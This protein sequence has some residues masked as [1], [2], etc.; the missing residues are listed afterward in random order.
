MKMRYADVAGT[1]GTVW[2]AVDASC[3]VT[4]SKAEKVGYDMNAVGTYKLNGKLNN[5][6][7]VLTSYIKLTSLNKTSKVLVFIKNTHIEIKIFNGVELK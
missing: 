5:G 7:I 6:Y 2:S 1:N 3:E 4:D